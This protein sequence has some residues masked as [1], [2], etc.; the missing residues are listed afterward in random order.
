[1]VI[2][3][4][5]KLTL[6]ASTLRGY[7][8]R[9]NQAGVGV[10]AKLRRTVGYPQSTIKILPGAASG[11]ESGGEAVFFGHLMGEE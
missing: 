3:L 5:G 7:K 4:E 9:Q 6:C 11:A 2:G 8:P 10:G 1:M